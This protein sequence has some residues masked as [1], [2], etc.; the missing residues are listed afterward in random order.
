MTKNDRSSENVP[1]SQCT[2][3]RFYNTAYIIKHVYSLH[4]M[5]CMLINRILELEK[6]RMCS[7][8]KQI[9]PK[10]TDRILAA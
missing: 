8:Y 5:D 4:V 2:L 1:K 10:S 7:L 3:E 6:Q 9:W